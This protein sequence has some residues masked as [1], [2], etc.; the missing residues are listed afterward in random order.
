[1]KKIT[2]EVSSH[3]EQYG[4]IVATV[5]DK[6]GN[7]KQ[8]VEQPVDSFNRQIWRVLQRDLNGTASSL[9]LTSLNNTS[10]TP[11]VPTIA[12]RADAQNNSYR[13]IVVG[14]G[15]ALTTYDTVIMQNLIDLGYGVNELVG[16]ESTAEVDYTNLICTQTRSF[17]NLNASSGVI[18]VNEVGIALGSTGTTNLKTNC[19]LFVRDI[20]E[21]TVNVGYEETLT[22]QYRLRISNGNRN[23]FN[24]VIRPFGRQASLV[25]ITDASL[26]N[27]TNVAVSAE[28]QT[29]RAISSE[30]NIRA[31][32]VFGSSNTPF[33]V[34]QI[35]LA[36]KIVH[37]NSAGQLFY[38]PSTNTVIEENSAT[39]SMRFMLMRTVEN[40]TGSDVSIS[41][42][43]VF[44]DISSST[45]SFMLDR[46][47]VNP[48]VTVTNGNTVT[49]TWEYCYEV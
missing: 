18:S 2:S 40:R 9:S 37:G 45:Q 48:P 38:H 6:Y 28:S 24:V 23:Y 47:P 8:R 31:G 27:I 49:F 42:V 44:T 25:G 26:T 43:G 1:M 15:T 29:L 41:E 4:T 34:S 33:D 46:K 13:G 17:I 3:K 5:H 21:S 39:N 12:Y 35:D 30:G 16:Q 19:V 22:I 14:T 32:L 7:L 36:S 10:V 20:L 11:G